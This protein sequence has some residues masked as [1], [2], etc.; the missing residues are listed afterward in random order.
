[1]K[2]RSS[3]VKIIRSLSNEGDLCKQRFRII[4]DLDCEQK[5]SL[6]LIRYTLTERRDEY[7]KSGHL[8]MKE[9]KG[10]YL[11][12]MIYPITIDTFNEVLK[13]LNTISDLI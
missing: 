12:K 3:E 9:Y 1:M 13:W 7:I 6:M 5:T 4:M 2:I 8:L 10:R 11:M